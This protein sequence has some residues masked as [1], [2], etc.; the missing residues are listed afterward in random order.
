MLN[1]S[2]SDFCASNCFT[3]QDSYLAWE[4]PGIG[5]YLTFLFIQGVFYFSLTFM[6]ELGVPNKILY[7]L[8]G[9]RSLTRP[10]TVGSLPSR[11]DSRD[12][13]N[14]IALSYIS[15]STRDVNDVRARSDSTHSTRDVD[16]VRT[17]SHSSRSTREDDDV[18]AEQNRIN[19]TTLTK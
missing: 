14:V 12:V 7:A 9:T 15:C 17:R 16:D 3:Y 2:I 10:S 1:L 18:R 13:D 19:S 11:L 8:K 5:R 6:I 4:L